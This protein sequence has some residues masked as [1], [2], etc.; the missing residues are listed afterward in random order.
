MA[1]KIFETFWIWPQIIHDTHV[2]ERLACGVAKNTNR[3]S[4]ALTSI[5]QA[6]AALDSGLTQTKMAIDL[7][8]APTGLGCA[9][10]EEQLGMEGFCCLDFSANAITAIDKVRKEAKDI[11]KS[12]L[13]IGIGKCWNFLSNLLGLPSRENMLAMVVS[14]LD[15]I[16]L[17]ACLIPLIVCTVH[18]ALSEATGHMLSVN[19]VL[20][21]CE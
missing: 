7:L 20:G 1:Q 4:P 6:M 18:R 5:A 2:T 8:L 11:A 16:L 19:L 10:M 17:A 12:V 21:A 9:E 15:V 3:T 13:K 14:M